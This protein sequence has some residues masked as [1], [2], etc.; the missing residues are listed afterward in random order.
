LAP[1]WPLV[2]LGGEI[3]SLCFFLLLESRRWLRVK[4]RGAD[5]KP[6]TEASEETGEA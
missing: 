6:T 3:P 5:G 2:F 1:Q 4:I